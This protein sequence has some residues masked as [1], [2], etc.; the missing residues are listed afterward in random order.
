MVTNHPLYAF[1]GKAL[2]ADGELGSFSRYA[3]LQKEVE[4]R[5]VMSADDVKATNRCVMQRFTDDAPRG[6]PPVRTLWHAVYD[7]DA[8]TLEVDFYLGDDP[9]GSDLRQRRS[10]YKTFK[11]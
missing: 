10:G 9:Q 5:G 1:E 3:R 7:L 2:P 11:L 8:L 4:A 6:R